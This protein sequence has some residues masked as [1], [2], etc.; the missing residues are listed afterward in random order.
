MRRMRAQVPKVLHVEYSLSLG[1]F[2][3]KPLSRLLPRN[4]SHQPCWLLVVGYPS[5]KRC[6]APSTQTCPSQCYSYLTNGLKLHTSQTGAE[7]TDPDEKQ[8]Q[9][10]PERAPTTATLRRSQRSRKP[11]GTVQAR[12]NVNLGLTRLDTKCNLLQIFKF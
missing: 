12:E 11:P 9:T 4:E 5:K 3:T 10:V 1:P 2:S 7:P 6:L 8:E